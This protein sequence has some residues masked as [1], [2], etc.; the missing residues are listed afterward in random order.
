MAER[1]RAPK[2]GNVASREE[3]KEEI[4]D[5]ERVL[6]LE[7]YDIA[8]CSLCNKGAKLPESV[9][10]FNGCVKCGGFGFII[11]KRSVSGRRR[12]STRARKDTP[13]S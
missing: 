8:F 10:D 7:R 12:K 6:N 1:N 2:P 3:Q 4:S 13:V 9:D 11:R 5:V